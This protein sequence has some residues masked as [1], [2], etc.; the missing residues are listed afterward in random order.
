LLNLTDPSFSFNSLIIF[1]RIENNF[2]GP[3]EQWMSTESTLA[4]GAQWSLPA[5]IKVS[6]RCC[7]SLTLCSSLSGFTWAKNFCLFFSLSYFTECNLVKRIQSDLIKQKLNHIQRLI[8]FDNSL[9]QLWALG[10]F[11]TFFLLDL[12]L[13][14]YGRAYYLGVWSGWQIIGTHVLDWIKDWSASNN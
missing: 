7:T 13:R 14:S 5:K 3:Q 6:L 4:L 8:R 2:Q 12:K 9:S 11:F 1:G 10:K